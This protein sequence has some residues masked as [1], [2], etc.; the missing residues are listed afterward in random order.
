MFYCR[1]VGR[2]KPSS[3]QGIVINP[4][5]RTRPS[6][7]AARAS[8]QT[9]PFSNKERTLESRPLV[10]ADRNVQLSDIVKEVKKG[11]QEAL[12]QQSQDEKWLPHP[13]RI[14]SK[15]KKQRASKKVIEDTEQ[16][17]IDTRKLN[18]KGEG[19][20]KSK[21]NK[22]DL[23]LKDNIVVMISTE[24]NTDNLEERVTLPKE[25]ANLPD[26]TETNKTSNP[27]TLVRTRKRIIV[28]KNNSSVTDEKYRRSLWDKLIKKRNIHKAR[29]EES[30]RVLKLTPNDFLSP[31]ENPSQTFEELHHDNNGRAHEPLISKSQNGKF[32]I[33]STLNELHPHL[34]F[35][36]HKS[37]AFT[38]HSNNANTN[39]NGDIEKDVKEVSPRNSKR[40][41]Q[42]V[43]QTATSTTAGHKKDGLNDS[44][45]KTT[46]S[47]HYPL[48]N[49]SQHVTSE[50][51][52][53]M[54]ETEDIFSLDKL[55]CSKCVDLEHGYQRKTVSHLQ[56]KEGYASTSNKIDNIYARKLRKQFKYENFLRQQRVVRM[57]FLIFIMMVIGWCPIS[58]NFI[59]DKANAFP[60]IYYVAF[61][62]LAW[63]N[64]WVN[65]FVYA[66][67]NE[68]FRS[69]YV[70]LLHGKINIPLAQKETVTIEMSKVLANY[71]HKRIVK[72]NFASLRWN[73]VLNCSKI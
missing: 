4:L 21:H 22:P 27:Q 37:K 15:A 7:P 24:Q 3:L 56:H 2:F 11:L 8:I 10:E 73:K 63:T 67:L 29:H 25:M 34:S 71:F 52:K 40:H 48:N 26:L 12:A 41:Q 31:P 1:E 69:A 23:S 72:P 6:T 60:S 53:L 70:N 33:N 35:I 19:K 66:W 36:N 61:T 14:K 65:I 28:D 47:S 42:S 38:L 68:Q 20:L 50:Q 51:I 5:D 64:S 43:I 55:Q 59:I 46:G 49:Q 17:D 18:S 9:L 58:I 45:P 16:L 32:V 44:L 39:D 57:L 54:R 62:I 30:P 13:T